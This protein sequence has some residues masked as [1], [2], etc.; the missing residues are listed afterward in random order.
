M[1]SVWSISKTAWRFGF[2]EARETLL[3]EGGL[4]VWREWKCFK[5]RQLEKRP[6]RRHCLG[7]K[8]LVGRG[9]DAD[10]IRI[11]FGAFGRVVIFEDVDEGR[12]EIPATAIQ[13]TDLQMVQ[14]RRVAFESDIVDQSGVGWLSPGISCL[15]SSTS[16]N[17]T[18]LPNAP[19]R[20]VSR[21]HHCRGTTNFL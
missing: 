3:E 8:K 18:T 17:I 19:T 13:R 16:S 9:N 15:P 21:R 1:Y 4:I 14:C 12:H 7:H 10:E 5:K 20:S 6:S 2:G 11:V